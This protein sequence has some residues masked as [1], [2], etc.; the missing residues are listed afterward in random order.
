MVIS[1]LKRVGDI[2]ALGCPTVLRDH[3]D[4]LF[5]KDIGPGKA[6]SPMAS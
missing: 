5:C 3:R 4:L 6:K 2:Q 1:S